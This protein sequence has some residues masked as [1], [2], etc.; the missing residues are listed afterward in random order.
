[1]MQQL[2]IK[3]A[4]W[5]HDRNIVAGST[6]K[7]Q[8]AKLIEELGELASG[9]VKNKSQLIQDSIGDMAVVLTI[10]EAIENHPQGSPVEFTNHTNINVPRSA[11]AILPDV[12]LQLGLLTLACGMLL[13][14]EAQPVFRQEFTTTPGTHFVWDQ[15]QTVAELC[16]TS[17][18]H[19]TELA[20]D[21]IKDRKGKLLNGVFVKEGDL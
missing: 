16:G 9:I 13:S 6:T 12:H 2:Q 15:L 3:I 11:D 14:A 18:E 17:I 1:M 20:Y 8:A 21:E 7:D 4:Q 5:A 19:C 10:Y